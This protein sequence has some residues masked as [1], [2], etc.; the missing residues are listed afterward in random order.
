MRKAACEL[1]SGDFLRDPQPS[2][3]LQQSC[4]ELVL[5]LLFGESETVQSKSYI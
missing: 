3:D 2:G 1:A 4:E 5:I